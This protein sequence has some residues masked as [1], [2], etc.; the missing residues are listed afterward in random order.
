MNRVFPLKALRHS[1]D[2]GAID[3]ALMKRNLRRLRLLHSV[4]LGVVLICLISSAFYIDYQNTRNYRWQIRELGQHELGQLTA[5]LEGNLKGNVQTSKALVAAINANPKLDQTYFNLYSAPLFDENLQLH[6]LSLTQNLR[7]THVYPLEGNEAALNLDFRDH[8]DQLADLLIAR[9]SKQPVLSGPINLVQGGRAI[10]ARIPVVLASNGSLWGTI[11]AVINIDLL[12]A[13]SGIY[14]SGS[15]LEIAIREVDG[16]AIS[17]PPLFG[18]AKLFEATSNA[19]TSRV[20]LPYENGWELAAIPKG[21]WPTA[22]PNA[23]RLRTGLAIVCSLLFLLLTYIS[24]L[25][26]RQ[27]ISNIFLQSLFELSPVGI[28]L[29]DYHSGRLLNTNKALQNITGL[30]QD[31]LYKKNCFSLLSKPVDETRLSEYLEGQHSGNSQPVATTLKHANGDDISVLVNS[32]LIRDIYGAPY[33]WAIIED[34][35]ER[36]LAETTLRRQQEMFESMSHQA[37]IGAWE[38]DLLNRKVYWS[39]TT[40]EIHEVDAEYEPDIDSA[41]AFYKDGATRQRAFKLN[42]D[43][44]QHGTTYNEE[45]QIITAKGRALWVQATGQAEFVNGE[46]VRLFGSFQDIDARKKIQSELT[47][48]RDKAETAAR[49]KS[50]FLTTMSHEIRT[51]MNGVLGMLSL[52]EN[53]NL[54]YDQERKI[55]IAKR[56]AQTLLSLIDDVLDFSRIDAGKMVLENIDFDL[57][58]EVESLAESMALRIQEKGLELVL[59]LSTIEAAKLRGDPSRLRQILTNLIANAIKFTE[60]G[61]IIVKINVYHDGD[62]F[63]LE[64]AVIDSGVG[65]PVDKQQGL[66]TEF[67]QADASTTRRYGGSG[68]G[69]SIC[70]KLCD[71]MGGTI[72][73]QSVPG[74]GSSFMFNLPMQAA[75]HASIELEDVDASGRTVLLVD[76]NA[77]FRQVCRQQLERW[78]ATVLEAEN[79]DTALKLCEDHH[80]GLAPFD[81]AIVDWHLRS[82]LDGTELVQFLRQEARFA[83]VP[84]VLLGAMNNQSGA[85]HFHSFGLDAW[86]AKPLR[87]QALIDILSLQRDPDAAPPLAPVEIKPAATQDASLRKDAHILLVEDNPV[88]QEVVK[89]LL[90]EQ[91]IRVSVAN[92][93]NIAI[94]KLRA[95]SNAPEFTLI[96]MDCQMPQMDGYETTR[97]IRRGAAGEQYK[98]LPIIALTANALTGDR[99]KCSAAGMDDYLSKPIDPRRLYDKL[100]YWMRQSRRIGNISLVEDPHTRNTSEAS[101]WNEQAALENLLGKKA[102]LDR[103]LQIFCDQIDGQLQ[104][105]ENALAKQDL[106]AVA[107]IVHTIKGS[108][109]QLRGQQL[110]EAAAKLE[111]ASNAGNREEVS[112]LYPGFVA[113]CQQLKAHFLAFLSLTADEG[114][115]AL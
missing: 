26:M 7:V 20:K 37:R 63:L 110:Q 38:M 112:S 78:G 48:A 103:L 33:I 2:N 56:S 87:H 58:E 72:S 44:I 80:Q 59:D 86:Y 25:I 97:Q 111:A 41:V 14:D 32:S 73:V 45:L 23:L 6:N 74:H 114:R 109:G 113:N 29:V 27:Q 104:A 99:E 85:D 11:S 47:R 57:I 67:T 10:I 30:N 94:A 115:R 93:G 9:R 13:A 76:D 107:D 12:F 68:L 71:L 70:R 5:R 1:A 96:L 21:G 66:F 106:S 40:R 51:P 22:A 19:V 101:L 98:R 108:A 34:I 88:N 83:N 77:T 31:E 55:D 18:D 54:S 4:A 90:V 17:R 42:S 81:L 35:S 75:E 61:E 92:D 53:S 82:G 102:L 24:R 49:T 69:L 105:I 28:A 84:M 62:H 100:S 36:Q 3:P 91:G 89:G 15:D 50:E 46:C 95:Q 64:G 52:L 8:P 43:C 39:A 60:R 79:S 65:I 16:R